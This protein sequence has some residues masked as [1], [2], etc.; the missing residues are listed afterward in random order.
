VLVV[1]TAGWRV[2]K[3]RRLLYSALAAL[4]GLLP[5]VYLPAAASSD[6]LFNWGDPSTLRSFW[7]H[8]TGWQYRIFFHTSAE[9]FWAS[10]EQ[11]VRVLLREFGPVWLPLALVVGACGLVSLFRRSLTIFAFV[12]LVILFDLAYSLQYEIAEDKDAYYLPVFVSL[13]LSFGLGAE[14]LIRLATAKTR[15]VVSNVVAAVLILLP[16]AALA[17]NF[18]FNNRA[19]YTIARDY[20][21]N[22][23]GTIDQR[24]MLLTLDWQVY[25]PALYLR[26]IE[27][28]RRDIVW[29]D[30]NLLRRSWYFQ[31]LERAYPEVIQLSRAKVEL[32]LED[33]RRW[34][35]DPDIFQ[36]DVT[37]NQRINSRFLDMI[38][39]FTTSHARTS[40]V[41]L[42]EEIAT[43]NDTLDGQLTKQLSSNYQLVPQGLVFQLSADR[44]FQEPMEPDLETRGLM[45]GSLRFEEGDVVKLK[46]LPA[47]VNMLTNRGLYL[48]A[49]GRHDR[50]VAAFEKALALDPDSNRA[51]RGR[52]DS[53]RQLRK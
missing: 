53:L 12:V 8:V 27:A 48:A 43:G 7:Q 52:D 47:Y 39:A 24:G 5:Y 23:A 45:D 18:S 36:R 37:L 20:V 34:E 25:S 40:P 32:F 50:A 1:S 15:L 26:E 41:Y 35:R 51:R 38:L 49:H 46:V 31:Y 13:T 33:L 22:M 44:G 28:Y 19:P 17:G 6:P 3:T 2:L 29:I 30:V 10:V 42:T 16:L 14:A 9:I 11:F 21:E 4:A